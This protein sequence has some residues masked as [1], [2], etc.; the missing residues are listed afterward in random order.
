MQQLSEIFSDLNRPV[1]VPTDLERDDTCFFIGME[2]RFGLHR[3]GR[4][5]IQQ[6]YA[7]PKKSFKIEEKIRASKEEAFRQLSGL[8]LVNP[9]QRNEDGKFD[10]TPI[11]DFLKKFSGKPIFVIISPLFN[12]RL[13]EILQH[14][15]ESNRQATVVT[16]SGQYNIR[17]NADHLLDMYN[18]NLIDVLYDFSK[19]VF[20]DPTYTS[21]K[22]QDWYTLTPDFNYWRNKLSPTQLIALTDML[23]LFNSGHLEPEKLFGKNNERISSEEMKHM[24]ELYA[25]N[26]DEY[27]SYVLGKDALVQSAGKKINM[28]RARHMSAALADDLI[29]LSFS[30]VVNIHAQRGIWQVRVDDKGDKTSYV[31][32]HVNGNAYVITALPP[33]NID[34][35]REELWSYMSY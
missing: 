1:V 17:Y 2:K 3:S 21:G 15:P 19:Y 34:A 14:L 35:I 24:K 30:S 7:S 13:D 8:P 9:I 28:I 31:E 22:L 12:I 5:Y 6:C 27:C 18:R 33:Y 29:P 10:A 20:F 23:C 4:L 26:I 32:E 11:V 25:S 16:Y